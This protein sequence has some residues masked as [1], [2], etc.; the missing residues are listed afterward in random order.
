M[1]VVLLAQALHRRQHQPAADDPVD[2]PQLSQH[3]PE[4]HL[5]IEEQFDL[6]G[7]VGAIEMLCAQDL[8]HHGEVQQPLSDGQPLERQAHGI[9]DGAGDQQGRPVAGKQPRETRHHEIRCRARAL[10]RHEDHEPADQEEKIDAVLPRQ[11]VDRRAA[12]VADLFLIPRCEVV[13]QHG[14]GGDA[15]QGIQFHHPRGRRRF[16]THP[17]PLTRH[18]SALTTPT[19]PRGGQS[20][21]PLHPPSS[22]MRILIVTS[23]FPIAGEPHRGRR[24]TRPCA[25]CR[26]WRT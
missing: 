12:H 25:T 24:S 10:Q 6:Q 2:A 3:V 26:D 20:P 4:Q 11:Q 7:P 14:D 8:L 15:A 18:A 23:Q 16:V 13:A 17:V 22:R 21:R 1:P 19:A 5:H 9:D